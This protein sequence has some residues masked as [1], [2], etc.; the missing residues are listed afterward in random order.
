M[1]LAAGVTICAKNGMA[2]DA[3][4]L[5]NEMSTFASRR[6]LAIPPLPRKVELMI[7]WRSAPHEWPTPMSGRVPGWLIG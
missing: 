1:E 7:V 4:L 3:R 2:S 6:A 5:F